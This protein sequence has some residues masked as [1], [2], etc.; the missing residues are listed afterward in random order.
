[1]SS[2]GNSTFR[3]KESKI[4]WLSDRWYLASGVRKG[5]LK[6]RFPMFFGKG[7]FKGFL[8]ENFSKV[9]GRRGFQWYLERGFLKVFRGSQQRR[10]YR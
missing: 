9:F 1:M 6:E 8:K 3:K 5:F 10:F 4:H 7:F 2:G